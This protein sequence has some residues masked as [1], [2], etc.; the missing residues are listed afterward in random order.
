MSL[1]DRKSLRSAKKGKLSNSISPA[2]L[3]DLVRGELNVA[4]RIHF[5]AILFPPAIGF[6]PRNGAS[7]LLRTLLTSLNYFAL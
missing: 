1:S 3:G 4:F 5:R 7:Y 2:E 6:N